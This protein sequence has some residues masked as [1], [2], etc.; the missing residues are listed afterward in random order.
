MAILAEKKDGGFAMV[1]AGSYVARCIS[2][3]E[4]GTIPTDYGKG[5]KKQHKVNVTWELP[6]ELHVFDEDKGAQPFI[7]S[8]KYTLSMHEKSNLRKDLESWRGQGYTEEEAKCLDITKLLGQP[9][10]LTI[11]HQPGKTDATKTYANIASVSKLMRG[12]TCPPQINPT[13]IL[14]FDNFDWDIF[15]GLADYYKDMIKES[16][17]FKAMQNPGSVADGQSISQSNIDANVYE[18][19][20]GKPPF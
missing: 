1:D 8:K 13:K 9:C 3:I 11:I 2:M 4:I 7:V 18:E 15:D 17:E 10:I 5:D 20:T 19:E 16:D 14:S 6:T 12:Q